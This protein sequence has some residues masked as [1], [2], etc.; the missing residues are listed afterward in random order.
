M[1]AA[2]LL[3]AS[4]AVGCSDE[5]TFG[6]VEDARVHGAAGHAPDAPPRKIVTYRQAMDDRPQACFG[7]R[8]VEP[9]HLAPP[10]TSGSC[11]EIGPI[12]EFDRSPFA[13]L[14]GPEVQ[15]LVVQEADVVRARLHG[16]GNI[17]MQPY[18]HPDLAAQ[19][20]GFSVGSSSKIKRLEAV[21]ASG[22]ILGS[23]E[24]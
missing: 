14:S 11:V 10:G 24:P 16:G 3:V 22:E 18:T 4:F 8:P 15:G 19:V 6:P 9:Q 13:H 7:M 21:D 1:A 2:A 5:P 20:F 17:E 12:R 23:V